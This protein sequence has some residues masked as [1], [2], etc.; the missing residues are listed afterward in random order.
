MATT[1]PPFAA[2]MRSTGPQPV[3]PVQSR[4]VTQLFFQASAARP[5]G[6]LHTR[7]D[8]SSKPT[9]T[10][11]PNAAMPLTFRGVVVPQR[12]VCKSTQPLVADH[13]RTVPSLRATMNPGAFARV[14]GWVIT[15]AAT[16]WE[17]LTS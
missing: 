9:M 4:V 5:S 14:A 10:P 11:S 13:S 1:R 16:V 3:E 8:P 6:P 17:L 2:T 7:S 12:L 15:V